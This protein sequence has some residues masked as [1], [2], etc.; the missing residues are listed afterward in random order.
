MNRNS[1]LLGLISLISLILSAYLVSNGVNYNLIENLIQSPSPIIDSPSTTVSPVS[2]GSAEIQGID[3]ER[4]KV[5]K[6]VDG[7]TIIVEGDRTVRFIGIDTPETVDPRRPVGCFGKE[8]SNKVKELLTDKII[9]LQKDISET[10]KYSR[11]LRYIY[12]P[13]ENGQMV[14]MND[15]LVREGYAKS[16]SYPP[17]VKY[18]EQFIEA[19]RQAQENNRGLWGKC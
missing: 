2:T 9:I 11:L 8:A 7:D 3:G 19:Q 14:F 6:V 18:Q 4:T 1:L 10:D 17:D 16:S 15:Y 5:I 13:L 12:L